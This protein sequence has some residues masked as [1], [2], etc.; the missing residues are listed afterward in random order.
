MKISYTYI[1]KFPNINK[2]YLDV[3]SIS[4]DIN[5]EDDI[6]KIYPS[7]SSIVNGMLKVN[8]KAEFYVH[9]IFNNVDDGFNYEGRMLKTINKFSKLRNK[10][11]NQLLGS[12]SH[13]ICA[14][15]NTGK[16]V[17]YDYEFRSIGIDSDNY[18]PSYLYE[19]KYMYALK[20]NIADFIHSTLFPIEYY[21]DIVRNL[22]FI[23]K[24]R[25]GVRRSVLA[26]S[27]PTLN[28]LY[29]N[30]RY[31]FSDLEFIREF[32]SYRRYTV[33]D[34]IYAESD[35]M[36]RIVSI[37]K[38]DKEWHS[39]IDKLYSVFGDCTIGTIKHKRGGNFAN[40]LNLSES[41]ISQKI[42]EERNKAIPI[43]N[44]LQKIPE[45]IN[46]H[47]LLVSFTPMYD[48]MYEQL[49]KCNGLYDYVVDD[50]FDL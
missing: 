5:P 45:K 37:L 23:T 2:F 46:D 43:I 34:M 9:R 16:R 10:C 6:G 13:G 21:P 28:E 48:W 38:I 19:K 44:G 7:P 3:R 4:K 15:P 42:K 32:L 11:L 12:I 27:Y 47:R 33:K 20:K 24:R 26:K 39:V 36:T 22:F 1:I 17:V 31:K 35:R 14:S 18:I 49:I 29:F 30:L 40:I 50:E 8:V 25:G 41:R